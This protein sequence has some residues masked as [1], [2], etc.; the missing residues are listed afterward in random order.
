MTVF[1]INNPLGKPIA[2]NDRGMGDFMMK[3]DMK[4]I[5][6]GHAVVDVEEAKEAFKPVFIENPL[7]VLGL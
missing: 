4:L 2:T 5:L 7:E 1:I 6:L 3:I